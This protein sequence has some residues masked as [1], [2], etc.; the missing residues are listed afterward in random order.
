MRFLKSQTVTAAASISLVSSLRDRL[1]KASPNGEIS[2]ED[3]KMFAR[4]LTRTQ[5]MDDAHDG[6]SNYEFDRKFLFRCLVL[7]NAQ[8][9]QL[10]S[11]LFLFMFSCSAFR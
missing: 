7:G 11:A 9:A 2:D 4:L 8:L 10:V 6:E 3:E 1:V 5:Q